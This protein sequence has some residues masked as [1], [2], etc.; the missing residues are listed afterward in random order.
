MKNLL[1]A[2]GAA[3]LTLQLLA[4]MGVA[5]QYGIELDISL[6]KRRD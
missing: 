4:A 1:A 3:W 2:I 5:D 6:Q